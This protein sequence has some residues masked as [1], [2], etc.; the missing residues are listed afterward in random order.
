MLR[1]SAKA[2]KAS[3]LAA[4]S[5]SASFWLTSGNSSAAA[6]TPKTASRT[7]ARGETRASGR[8]RLNAL[9]RA[10]FG[11]PTPAISGFRRD[12]AAE[13]A[14]R[15]KDEN[16]NQ[17]RKD[18]HV[19]PPH[20]DQLAAQGLDQPDQDASNHGARHAADAAEHR[21][22][23]GPQSRCV[24]DDEAR[25]VVIE[26]EDQRRRPGQRRPEKKRRDYDPIDI[27]PHHPGGLGVLRGRAHRFAEAGTVDE[28]MER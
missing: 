4:E 8:A 21:G 25:V 14:G 28:K 26:A 15:D 6:V 13:E 22:G 27:D 9:P 23:K 17:D 18:D 3:A 20:G 16:Q 24:A 10:A 19:G 5:M 2:A 11:T 1:P 12:G 7:R